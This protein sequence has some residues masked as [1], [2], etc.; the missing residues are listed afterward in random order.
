MT[1]AR[2][3]RTSAEPSRSAGRVALL[4]E[5]VD[6]LA[7]AVLELHLNTRAPAPSPDEAPLPKRTTNFA[8]SGQIRGSL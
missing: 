5:V 6:I 7:V 3:G 1:S 8:T 4:A 2:N